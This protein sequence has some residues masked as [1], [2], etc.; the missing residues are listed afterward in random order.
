MMVTRTKWDSHRVL[1]P[2]TPGSNC[3]F[4]ILISEDKG[5]E[6][7]RLTEWPHSMRCEPDLVL[8]LP[9]SPADTHGTSHPDC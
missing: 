9:H 4:P 8:S 1:T 7:L 2:T 5:S 3:A 6:K